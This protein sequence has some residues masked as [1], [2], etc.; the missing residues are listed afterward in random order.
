MLVRNLFVRHLFARLSSV[1]AIGMATAFVMVSGCQPSTSQKTTEVS[2]EPAAQEKEIS[3]K[4]EALGAKLQREA[5]FIID[6]DLRGTESSDETLPILQ[7]LERLRSLHLDK[8]PISDSGIATIGSFKGPLAN[9][10]IRNC[11]ITDAAMET[12][13]GITTLKA[14][15]LSGES[16]ATSV[17]DDGVAKLAT[18]K[19]LKVLAVDDLWVSGTALEALAGLS[20]IE[21][22]YLKSTLVDDDAMTMVARFPNL[23]KLRISKTQVSND[24]LQHL[25]ACKK[26]EDLDLSENSL[27][28]DQGMAIVGQMTSLKKLN[29]WRDAI[30]DTGLQHLSPLV[31]L[32]WLNVDNTQ[33]SDAGLPALKDMSQLTFL[34]LGSTSVSDAGMPSLEHLTQLKDLKVTRTAVTEEGVQALQMKLPNTAIQLKYIEGE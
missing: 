21:E 31:N 29:L 4:L 26:L 12:L 28:D 9:L 16:S 7:P 32:A 30:S 20:S 10:D 22:L 14:I 19:N 3:S 17:G 18:L 27:L 2:A 23:K 5:G 11:A 8:L 6:V 15:R 13:S 25:T 24:G 33:V 1:A 34:H